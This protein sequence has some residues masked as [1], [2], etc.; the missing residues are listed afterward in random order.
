MTAAENEAIDRVRAAR[1]ALALAIEAYKAAGFGSHVT[2]MLLSA[3]L[4]VNHSIC[5]VQS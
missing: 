3:A 2:S 4:E 5:E 1:D